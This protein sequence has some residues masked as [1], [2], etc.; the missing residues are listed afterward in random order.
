ME[1]LLQS[2]DKPLKKQILVVDDDLLMREFLRFKLVR[3]GFEVLTA[4]N[5]KEFWHLAFN[6]KPDLILLDLWLANKIGADIYDQLTAFG[7][8]PEVPVIFITGHIQTAAPA[9]A[10]PIRRKQMFLS[11]PFD[12][13]MLML[14][15]N[16]LLE[17]PGF[18]RTMSF[19]KSAAR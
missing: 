15:I 13:D 9:K 12:F 1:P 10:V 7:F 6:H 8:D 5:E 16:R 3:K 11:K 4:K 17:Y 14:E 19:A 2:V 18:E